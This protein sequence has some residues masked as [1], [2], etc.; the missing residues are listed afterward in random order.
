MLAP[1]LSK[2][3]RGETGTNALCPAPGRSSFAVR[4][5]DPPYPGSASHGD[6]CPGAIGVSREPALL[7]LVSSSG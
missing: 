4:S 1:G 2:E 3:K 7:Q 5:R 6:G